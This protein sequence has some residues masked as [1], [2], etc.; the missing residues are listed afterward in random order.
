M[1]IEPKKCTHDYLIL[2]QPQF[3]LADAFGKTSIGQPLRILALDTGKFNVHVDECLGG[4][5]NEGI[6]AL[7]KLVPTFLTGVETAIIKAHVEKT[8]HHIRLGYSANMSGGGSDY[9]SKYKK[10]K[11]KYNKLRK[12]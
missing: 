5:V 2:E 10:Y 6:L 12:N 4:K 11:A 3:L 7:N 1:A 8:N 9:F